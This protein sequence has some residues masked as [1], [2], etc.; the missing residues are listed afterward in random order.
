[1]IPSIPS[2]PTHSAGHISG[3]RVWIPVFANGLQVFANGLPVMV[4]LRFANA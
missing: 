1:M 2:I 4:P 3:V